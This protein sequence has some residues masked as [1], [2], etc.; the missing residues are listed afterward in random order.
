MFL[1]NKIGIGGLYFVK[2]L[3]INRYIFFVDGNYDTYL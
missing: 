2:D 3:W 1:D